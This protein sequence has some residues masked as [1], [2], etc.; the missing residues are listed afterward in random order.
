MRGSD[1][2]VENPKLHEQNER[3]LSLSSDWLK[4]GSDHSI[5]LLTDSDDYVTKW[6]QEFDSDRIILQDCLRSDG[7]TPNFLVEGNN[8]FENGRQIILD[9]YLGA[10]CQAFVGNFSSNVARYVAAIGRFKPEA[11]TWLDE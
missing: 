3:A 9:T 4:R 11:V 8:G 2:V 7:I 1:K 10:R 5:F 6:R